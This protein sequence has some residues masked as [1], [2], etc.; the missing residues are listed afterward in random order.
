VEYETWRLLAS[1][2][3][4][5]SSTRAALGEEVLT[6]IRKEPEDAVL[7]WPLGRL[8][9]RIPL[10]GPQHSVVAVD[11]A[12]E[13]L[14]ALLDLSTFTSATA[15]AIALIARRTEDQQRDLD[16]ALLQQTIARLQVLG[17]GEEIIQA[18]SKYAPPD[19]ADAIRAFGESLPAGLPVVSSAV[20]LLSVPALQTQ[21]QESA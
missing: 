4:L 7:L 3:H 19:R 21:R 5:Q 9:S 2:E 20:C 18:V 16:N 13:W 10:Y 8:G 15:T 6:R 12:E 17:V 11:V 1:L 14:R